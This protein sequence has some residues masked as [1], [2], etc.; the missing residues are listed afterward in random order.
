MPL[1]SLPW[2]LSS[3]IYSKEQG[4]DEKLVCDDEEQGALQQEV[5]PKSKN[6]LKHS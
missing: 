3:T 1:S 4:L 5:A 6:V 2:F